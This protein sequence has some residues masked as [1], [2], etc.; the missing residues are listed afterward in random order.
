[1]KVASH[2]K[3]INYPFPAHSCCEKN[4]EVTYITL[5]GIEKVTLL[6]FLLLLAMFWG[7]SGIVYLARLRN[8]T[9]YFLIRAQ[10]ALVLE[11]LE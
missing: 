3:S 1:M 8:A 2:A 9:G 10:T 4:P 5:L 6:R 7:D 11:I